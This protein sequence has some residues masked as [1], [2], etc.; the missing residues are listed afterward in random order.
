MSLVNSIA[1]A[2]G[3]ASNRT[4][5][6]RSLDNPDNKFIGQFQPTNFTENVGATLTQN[7][8][9]GQQQPTLQWSSGELET[10]TFGARLYQT[11]PIQTLFGDALSNP[12]GT[13]FSALGAGEETE[14]GTV[15]EQIDKLK[16]FTRKN[17]D[18]GRIERCMFSYGVEME[19]EVFVR[20]V[21]G[22]V[23]DDIRSDGTIRGATFQITLEKIKAENQADVAGTSLAALITSGIGI[24]STIAGAASFAASNNAINIPGGS[25]HTIGK[26]ITAKQGMS[27]ESIA[28]Q[29]Y[30]NPLLG[31][32]LRRAQPE[33]ANLKPGDKVILVKKEEILQMRVTPQAVALRNS[34]TNRT[35]L[36]EYLTL[37]G[38]PATIIV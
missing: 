16:Q 15:R 31:D 14:E 8:P 9:Q 20:S 37:R 17:P 34:Q 26:T 27:F 6:L 2:F 11:S 36:Q 13:A 10:V 35:L 5:R 18:F 24:I 29:E 28:L 25:L 21:G 32:I 1:T 12:I 7:Q 3:F 38:T 30:G 23:Y 33:R 4:W 22:I 19:F